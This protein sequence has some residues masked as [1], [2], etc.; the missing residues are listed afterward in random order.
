MKKILLILAVVI[1]TFASAQYV[2]TMAGK[3]TQK[4]WNGGSAKLTDAEFTDPYGLVVD[5][6]GNIWVAE[7]G[8]CRIRM[9]T[10]DLQSI[11]TRSGPL[12]DPA[13][14]PGYINS[15]ASNARYNGCSGIDMGADG[16][17]YIADRDNHCI[18][19][20]DKFMNIGQTQAVNLLAG[21]ES[22]TP[23]YING[24]GN[25]AQFT[26]P[27]DVAVDKNNNVYVADLAN[28]CI[29]KITPAGVVTLFAGTPGTT[30]GFADGAATSAKFDLPKGICYDKTNDVLY[31]ADLNNSRI[32]KI[33]ISTG[34]V[35]TIAGSGNSGNADGNALSAEITNPVDISLDG[36]GGMFIIDGNGSSMIRYL[37]N[38]KVT[39]VAGDYQYQGHKDTVAD[40]AWF[41]QPASISYI[42]SQKIAYLTDQNNHCIRKIDLKPTVNFKADKLTPAKLTDVNFTNLTPNQSSVSSFLW[43][44]SGTEGV[45]FNLNGGKLTD[46]NIKLQFLKNGLYTVTLQATNSFGTG[47]ITKTNYINVGNVNGIEPLVAASF[48]VFPNPSNDGNIIIEN[49]QNININTL[50]VSDMTGKTVYWDYNNPYFKQFHFGIGIGHLP[51]GMYVI[52]LTDGVSTF[53]QKV[54]LQ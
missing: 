51:K 23:G 35:S 4:G 17:L 22:Q 8:G 30:G 49:N 27:T 28:N 7:Y 41:D 54:V 50:L 52:T 33:I 32:R 11:Y 29:R 47:T 13:Q 44:V 1:S 40:K 12:T 31:V 24:T 10:G 48:G 15:S 16:A 18:R 6:S 21:S 5:A 25:A 2:T 37:S 14:A 42:P 19:K 45:D 36:S 46:A 39:T 34:V 20:L 26:S 9:I 43:T 53:H 38:G 3:P